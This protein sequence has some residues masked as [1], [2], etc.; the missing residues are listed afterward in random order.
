MSYRSLLELRHSLRK[1][2]EIDEDYLLEVDFH[3]TESSKNDER[4]LEMRKIA[5]V[6]AASISKRF[7]VSTWLDIY[8]THNPTGSVSIEGDYTQGPDQVTHYVHVMT[9]RRCV[10]EFRQKIDTCLKEIEEYNNMEDDDPLAIFYTE[11]PEEELKSLHQKLEY[12][13]ARMEEESL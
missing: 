11:D 8:E 13:L 9:H 10:R 3:H 6:N 7:K 5:M 12:H 1:K 4:V 2:I